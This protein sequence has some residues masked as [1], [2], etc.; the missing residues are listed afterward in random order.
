MLLLIIHIDN[1]PDYVPYVVLLLHN[2]SKIA[3]VCSQFRDGLSFVILNI[4]YF[5]CSICV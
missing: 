2:N 1:Y 3:C 4:S 5:S